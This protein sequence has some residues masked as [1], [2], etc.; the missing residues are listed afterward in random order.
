M[1]LTPVLPPWPQH[2]D[3]LC[4]RF[5]HLEISALKRL[6]GDPQRL[7]TYLAHR[8]DLTIAEAGEALEDWAAFGVSHMPQTVAA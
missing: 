1:S 8:H 3:Q 2:L 5:R 6:S 4:Q 7:A